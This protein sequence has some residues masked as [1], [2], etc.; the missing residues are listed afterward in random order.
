MKNY[1]LQKIGNL[2]DNVS[3]IVHE[4]NGHLETCSLPEA[5]EN[6]R[7][8]LLLRT[9]ILQKQ[10]LGAPDLILWRAVNN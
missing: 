3:K 2:L 1:I 6:S 7:K 10:S 5:I 9:D 4:W 8:F